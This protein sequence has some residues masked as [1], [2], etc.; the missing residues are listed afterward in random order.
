V[1]TRSEIQIAGDRAEAIAAI[2]SI[3][4]GRGWCNVVP[5]V[6]E[7]VK[8][9]APNVFSLW[10]KQ[11][12][13]VAT[14]VTMAPKKGVAQPSTLGILHTRGRLGG[15]RVASL[16]SGLPFEIRQDHTQRGLLLAV[17]EDAAGSQI[18]EA[19]CSVTAALCDYELTGTWRLT[20]FV[21]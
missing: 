9:L 7:D 21:R 5:D 16:L 15:E 11:G 10:A 4:S 8:D 14:F 6:R 19:M 1:T 20:L 3:R 13:P 17:P 12:A 18:L 2:E